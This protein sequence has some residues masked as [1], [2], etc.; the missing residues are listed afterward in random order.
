MNSWIVVV[1]LPARV[2]RADLDLWWDDFHLTLLR[3]PPP[4]TCVL[5]HIVGIWISH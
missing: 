4:I 3:S 2:P 5:P 1:D